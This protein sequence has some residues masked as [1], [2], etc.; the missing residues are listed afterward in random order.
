MDVNLL[1]RVFRGS[2]NITKE[3]PSFFGGKSLNSYH[4]CVS[5]LI[6]PP[7]PKKKWGPMVMTPLGNLKQP[8]GF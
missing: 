8:S 5:S 1:L 6:F 7:P 3:P 2:W 4:R